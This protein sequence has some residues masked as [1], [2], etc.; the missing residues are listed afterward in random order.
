M[1]SARIQRWAVILS[2]FDYTVE[3]IKGTS[4]IADGLSRMPHWESCTNV[5]EYH[6]IH[7]IQSNNS[8]KLSFKDIARETRRDPI[9][10]K[11]SEAIKN[12]TLSNLKGSEFS[13]YV[14]K[15]QELSI[16]YECV[17]W[18]YRVL[19]PLKLRK[20]ILHEFHKSHLGI[21]KTK[22]LIRSYIWWPAVDKEIEKLINTCIPCQE[23]QP[24]PEKSFLI[25]W[26]PTDTVWSRIHVDFAGPIKNYYL[27]V[28]ID[29]FSKWVEVYKTKEITSTFT[30]NK[31]REIFCRYGL[32]DTLVS[33][34]G[35]Q[36][37]SVEFQT[38][39]KNNSV[40]HILT[41]P[42][43]PSTNGQAENF[44]KTIKNHCMQV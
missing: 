30:I 1:A 29:S 40:K 14:S 5:E 35:R 19:V 3:Y 18:G 10:A 44:V 25:P 15:S 31:L 23:L 38:F 13:A 26:K 41:A 37:T 32:I 43:H 28:V 42:G 33:D 6:Y 36:F 17:L 34:N 4:N 2:G 8:I 20:Q 11:V 9:L 12:G 22:M 21:V 39:L 7:F 16:E 24:C 27:L